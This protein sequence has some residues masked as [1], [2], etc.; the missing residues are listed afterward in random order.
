[1]QDTELMTGYRNAPVLPAPPRLAV[2]RLRCDAGVLDMPEPVP[3]E[4]AF[5]V[6]LHLRDVTAHKWSLQGRS[7]SD[8][9]SSRC[10]PRP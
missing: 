8:G 9:P 7:R 4:S 5:L 2:T 6:N 10:N 1:M 3:V